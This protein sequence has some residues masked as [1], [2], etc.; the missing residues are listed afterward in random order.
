MSALAIDDP[1]AAPPLPLAGPRALALLCDPRDRP[2]L[3][4]I[5]GMLLV[6]VPAAL[7]V[8]GLGALGALTWQVSAAYLALLFVV[9]F[10]RFILMLHN[11]RHRRLWRPGVELDWVIECVLGPL[12]G[13]TPFT[14]HAHHLGMHHVE[15]NLAED[16]SSTLPFQ[17]DSALD[18]LR[19]WGRF[20][21]L[22]VASLAGYLRRKGR[23]K[24]ARR[25]VLGE[26]GYWLALGL[27]GA[28][29]SWEATLVV[30]GAPLLL[31]R[32]LMMAGNWAQH[33]FVD[34][35]EPGNPFRNSITVVNTR[36]N[37]RCF[38][39]GYHIGHHRRPSLHWS[40][41]PDE[42]LTNLE[43]Y[44]REGALVFQG[45]DYFQIWALLMVKDHGTLARH[46]VDLGHEPRT[47]AER[48]ALLRA[49]L[50]PVRG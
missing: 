31:A 34:P 7:L 42:L 45:L 22:G 27:L 28:L 35:A 10:D 48:V 39:D 44:R 5:G 6:Q 19:Y 16:E 3:G 9:F 14:Y 26:A 43:T 41:M 33:A 30:L 4:L 40:E 23:H 37:R 18:F 13:Q 24:L 8:F 29:V 17:R 11:T 25:A 46:L 38:N 32:F 49:R 50:V 20:L 1:R 15:G 12:C 36:Y 47:Q 21:L 2:F